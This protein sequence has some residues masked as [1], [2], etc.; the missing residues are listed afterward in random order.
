MPTIRP[1]G[2][3]QPGS[4]TTP[5]FD[6]PDNVS[7]ITISCKR[8]NWAEDAIFEAEVLISIDGGEYKRLMWLNDVGGD[9]FFDAGSNGP[10]ASTDHW[11]I[12]PVGVNRKV[13][14]DYSTN[15]RINSQFD[16]YI[17]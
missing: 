9:L 17:A 2:N 13:Y 15:V 4:Y 7:E 3:I 8:N 16:V 10:K 1:K 6:L 11:T 12:L 5:V 14:A